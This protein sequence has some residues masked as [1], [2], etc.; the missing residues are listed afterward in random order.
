[1]SIRSRS[2]ISTAAHTRWSQSRSCPDVPGS[3][4][5]RVPQDPFTAN[6]TMEC[7]WLPWRL[8]PRPPHSLRE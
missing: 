1:L 4:L 2:P 6:M 5:D 8:R 7:W 3:S